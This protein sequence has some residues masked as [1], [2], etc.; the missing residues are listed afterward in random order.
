LLRRGNRPRP[1]VPRSAAR[2]FACTGESFADG[3]DRTAPR[4][5]R[6]GVSLKSASK[7]VACRHPSPRGSRGPSRRF[8]SS[9]A[10]GCQGRRHLAAL[11]RP[12]C[13]GDAL[14]SQGVIPLAR[15]DGVSEPHK[16]RSQGAVTYADRRN[17]PREGPSDT[18]A[19][20]TCPPS[21]GPT[22]GARSLWKLLQP[23]RKQGGDQISGNEN[24]PHATS[25]GKLENSWGKSCVTGRDSLIY[26][27]PHIW[28]QVFLPPE[29]GS[30]IR[31]RGH[32]RP[33]SKIMARFLPVPP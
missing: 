31:G 17:G 12:A 24:I 29:G 4:C 28:G 22:E 27:E 23:G 15:A 16:E 8:P 2:R 25:N 5:P 19:G 32:Q 10:R 11:R 1:R 26:L 14:Q 13:T 6:R 3:S 7:D 21:R 33:V 30:L 18:T 9:Y 20:D